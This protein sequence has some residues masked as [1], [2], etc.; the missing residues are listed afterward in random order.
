MKAKAVAIVVA[1]ASLSIVL[2]PAISG[3]GIPFPP[4]PTFFFGLVEIPIIT[5]FLILGFKY[6]LSAAAI[7]CV[8][9]FTVW[10]GPS[11]PFVPLGAIGAWSSMM[12][13]IYVANFYTGKTVDLAHPIGKRRIAFAI[14]LAIVF[15]VV[16]TMPLMYGVLKL[17]VFNMPDLAILLFVFPWLA[18]FNTIQGLV[19]VPASFLVARQLGKSIRIALR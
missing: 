11:A 15:R 2:N 8:F 1:F 7:S 12:L 6:A 19:T 16:L 14:G 3:L 18:F 4:L 17:P 13:G 5:I 10:P 9:F